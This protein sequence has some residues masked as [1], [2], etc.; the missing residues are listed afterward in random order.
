MESVSDM[1]KYR[2]R[3]THNGS[4]VCDKGFFAYSRHPNYFG[5]IIMQFCKSKCFID[6]LLL[7]K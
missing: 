1:Q 4:D 3:K 5:E 6:Q 7:T 2:F